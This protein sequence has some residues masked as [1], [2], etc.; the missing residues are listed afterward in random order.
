MLPDDGG[1]LVGHG[2]SMPG[3]LAGVLV[4]RTAG[5][6]GVALANGTAG[7]DGL[8][9]VDLLTTLRDLEP[10]AGPAWAPLQA[11][12]PQELA[13]VGT[14][15]WGP[16]GYGLRLA[17][18]GLLHLGGIGAPGRASRFRS[19]GDGTYLGLEGYHAGEVLRVVRDDAG[20]PVALDLGSFVFSRTPY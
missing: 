10:A 14:W 1:A 18:D 5:V 4:D 15:Y 8:L 16:Y 7:L 13:L 17:A 12:D 20:E 2:G 11:A 19:R 3:F 9:V 6:G